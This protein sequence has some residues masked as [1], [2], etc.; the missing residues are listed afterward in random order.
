MATVLHKLLLVVRIRFQGVQGSELM[1]SWIDFL[2]KSIGNIVGNNDLVFSMPYPKNPWETV[3]LFG[4]DSSESL[5]QLDESFLRASLEWTE[6]LTENGVWELD[7]DLSVY[8][9]SAKTMRK[10][11]N[12]KRMQPMA[13]DSAIISPVG[14]ESLPTIEKRLLSNRRTKVKFKDWFARRGVQ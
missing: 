7:W 8:D 10:F 4:T 5:S 9:F 11:H 14:P 2:L 3:L 1:N 12:G 6:H 13:A